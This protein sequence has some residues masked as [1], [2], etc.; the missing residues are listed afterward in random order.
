MA[1]HKAPP[2]RTREDLISQKRLRLNQT[3][4]EDWDAVITVSLDPSVINRYWTH[5][6][7]KE[8]TRGGAVILNRLSGL[9]VT[10]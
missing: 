7:L 8:I 10:P 3:T 6:G 1:A 5:G 9:I 2:T 4:S